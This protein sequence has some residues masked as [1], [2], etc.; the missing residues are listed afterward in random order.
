MR[1]GIFQVCGQVTLDR[2]TRCGTREMSVLVLLFWDRVGAVT[3]E[4]G[5]VGNL[6]GFSG[7]K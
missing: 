2:G 5:G 7:L 3:W 6:L 1:R 4:I